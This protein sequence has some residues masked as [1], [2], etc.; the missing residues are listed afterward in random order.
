MENYLAIV[1][2]NL[3]TA[4]GQGDLIVRHL[5]LPGHFDCCFRPIVA[6]MKTHMPNAK[7]SVRDGYLPSWQADRHAE[8]SRPLAPGE[9]TRARDLAGSAGLRVVE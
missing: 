6:W 8:L 7:F 3:F 1:T 5:L 2:R 9:G 4:A